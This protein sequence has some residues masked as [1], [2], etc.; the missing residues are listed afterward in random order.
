MNIFVDT[1]ILID[2]SLDKDKILTK[3]FAKQKREKVALNINPIVVTEFL[4]DQ[5]LSRSKEKEEKAF[6]FLQ[7]FENVEITF[8]DGVLA[9]RLLREKKILFLTDSLIAA[10]CLN[11]DFLLATRNQK[12]FGK[13]PKLHFYS[14]DV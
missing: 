14:P 2:Y 8:K 6:Q 4:T 5:N 13:V 12:H 9:A 7:F 11:H 3:L 1:N 10:T